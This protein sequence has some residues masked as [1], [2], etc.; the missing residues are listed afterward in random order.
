ME[1][2]YTLFSNHE[3]CFWLWKLQELCVCMLDELGLYEKVLVLP[4]FPNYFSFSIPVVIDNWNVQSY[5]VV[6]YQLLCH[7][8][9]FFSIIFKNTSSDSFNQG[10]ELVQSE[11][12]EAQMVKN[13]PATRETWVWS[14][15]QEDP[16]E[17]GMATHSGILA[18]RILAWRIPWREAWQ[19]TVHGVAKGQIRLSRDNKRSTVW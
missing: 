13:P 6:G 17:K 8:R 12:L 9:S 19:A 5:I 14:L 7:L 10:H 11:D 4:L 16:L 2:L 15:G 1:I 18:W 3:C